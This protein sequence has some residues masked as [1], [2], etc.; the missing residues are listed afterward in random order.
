MSSWGPTLASWGPCCPLAQRGKRPP[1]RQEPGTPFCSLALCREPPRSCHLSCHRGASPQEK[2]CGR[3]IQQS[4]GLW[5]HQGSGPIPQG[6]QGPLL[7]AKKRC[8]RTGPQGASGAL[9]SEPTE[10]SAHLVYLAVQRAHLLWGGWADPGGGA[11]GRAGAEQEDSGGAGRPGGGGNVWH[12][13]PWEQGPGNGVG[14]LPSVCVK[15]PSPA[16]TQEGPYFPSNKYSLC[17]CCTPGSTLLHP[18][19][20]PF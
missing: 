8:P 15:P 17:V 20:P 12:E 9:P 7:A 14:S 6:S 1:G 3:D 13:E 18:G 11:A 5:A 19:R 10:C 2:G 16:L 4:R